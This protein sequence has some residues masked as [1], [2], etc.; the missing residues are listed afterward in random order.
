[1]TVPLDGGLEAAEAPAPAAAGLPKS[2]MVIAGFAIAMAG[3]MAFV[4]LKWSDSRTAAGE[5]GVQIAEVD[6]ELAQVRPELHTAEGQLAGLE[7]R[8][9]LL[10]HGKLAVC[11]F[12]AET[13]TVKMVAATWLGEEGEFESFNSTEHGLDLWRIPPGERLVLDRPASGWDGS[14]T[15]YSMWLRAQGQEFPF[16]GTWPPAEGDGGADG[17]DCV[18][19]S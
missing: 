1:M 7:E 3:L 17:D 10:A 15:Y 11:N 9:G 5:L 13:V 4:L 6:A 18:L 8:T 12:S 2:T 16:A 19:W 14:A